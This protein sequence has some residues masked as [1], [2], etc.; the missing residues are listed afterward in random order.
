MTIF[1]PK[2]PIEDASG[3]ETCK[4]PEIN[5]ITK[6]YRTKKKNLMTPPGLRK[7]KEPNNEYCTNNAIERPMRFANTMPTPM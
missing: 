3:R 1:A 4:R 6:T 5:P 2:G 7:T